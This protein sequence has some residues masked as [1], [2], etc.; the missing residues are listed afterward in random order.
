MGWSGE[1]KVHAL[2]ARVTK[3]E[4]E[5]LTGRFPAHLDRVSSRTDGCRISEP[6]LDASRRTFP[7]H[8][9]NL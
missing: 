6:H 3:Q 1:Q 8:S 9:P 2:R 7:A 5:S 4:V